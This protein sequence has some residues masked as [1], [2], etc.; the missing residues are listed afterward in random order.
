LSPLNAS[1]FAWVIENI[2]KTQ[3][4][5]WKDKVALRLLLN[6]KEVYFSRHLGYGKS[7]PKSKHKAIFSP[8]FTTKQR[9]W[10]LGLSLAKRIVEQYHREKYS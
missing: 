7:I 3:W 1:L 9:G 4:M 2:V 5:P 8:G 10:G 6:K